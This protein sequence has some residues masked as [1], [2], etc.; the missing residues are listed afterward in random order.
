[1]TTLDKIDAMFSG[2]CKWIGEI[3]VHVYCHHPMRE[4]PGP[5]GRTVWRRFE[6]EAR[7]CVV[8][9]DAGLEYI[10]NYRAWVP[11]EEA[12]ALVDRAVAAPRP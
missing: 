11:A 6:G 4:V 7:F 10:E 9:P 12:A 3:D 8:C 2:Q 1:M 5:H